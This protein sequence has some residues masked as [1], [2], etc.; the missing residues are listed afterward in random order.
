ML[1][2]TQ[3]IGLEGLFE[4][5]LILALFNT[6]FIYYICSSVQYTFIVQVGLLVFI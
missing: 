6:L 5:C 4:L 3:I 2:Q 1:I